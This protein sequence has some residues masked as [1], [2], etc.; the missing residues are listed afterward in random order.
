MTNN[1]ITELKRGLS[2]LCGTYRGLNISAET[3]GDFEVLE[4]IEKE[5]DSIKCKL[6]EL[7]GDDSYNPSIKAVVKKYRR[8]YWDFDEY[9]TISLSELYKHKQAKIEIIKSIHKQNG[10]ADITVDMKNI[11]HFYVEKKE[12]ESYLKNK[13]D[14][15]KSPNRRKRQFDMMMYEMWVYM[16]YFNNYDRFGEVRDLVRQVFGPDKKAMKAELNEIN[17]VIKLTKL[18]RDQL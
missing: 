11:N 16:Y 4:R 17:K 15:M 8:G 7:T 3:K 1:Q 12:V 6:L 10:V 13:R 2:T 18:L 9:G 5:I 14:K